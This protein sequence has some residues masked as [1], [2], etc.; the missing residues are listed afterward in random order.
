MGFPGKERSTCNICGEYSTR[1]WNKCKSSGAVR[2]EKANRSR[3]PTWQIKKE[4][5]SYPSLKKMAIIS[6]KIE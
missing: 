6:D 2:R 4:R 1:E 3:L 5:I